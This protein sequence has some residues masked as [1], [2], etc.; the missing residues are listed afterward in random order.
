MCFDLFIKLK[1]Q[2]QHFV[3]SLTEDTVGQFSGHRK[4]MAGI[5]SGTE[6]G[7]AWKRPL[8][9]KSLQLTWVHHGHLV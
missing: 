3:A 8:P 6:S 9:F 5:F 4:L 7:I 1:R 2:W